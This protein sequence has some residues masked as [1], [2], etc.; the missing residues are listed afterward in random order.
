MVYLVSLVTESAINVTDSDPSE[1]KK[2]ALK[3]YVCINI[4]TLYKL[5]ITRCYDNFAYTRV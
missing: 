5:L 2:F 3:H 4:T 1:M